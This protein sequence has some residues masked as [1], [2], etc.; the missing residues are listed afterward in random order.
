LVSDS[1]LPECGYPLIFHDSA[2]TCFS[3]MKLHIPATRRSFVCEIEIT[4]CIFLLSIEG[5]F[6]IFMM[7]T[8]FK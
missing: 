4:R 2:N 1:K 6:F 3:V 5:K 8:Q 7:S